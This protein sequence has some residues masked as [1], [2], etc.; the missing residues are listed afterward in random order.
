[1]AYGK[2]QM[3]PQRSKE[4]IKPVPQPLTSKVQQG[5]TGL[6]GAS[7]DAQPDFGG[8]PASGN[9]QPNAGGPSSKGGAAKG[10]KVGSSHAQRGAKVSHA[11]SKKPIHP[12]SSG[13]ASVGSI[14]TMTKLFFHPKGGFGNKAPAGRKSPVGGSGYK[15]SGARGAPQKVGVSR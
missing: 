2:P 13:G 4:G 15:D 1:M 6:E 5:K 8:L 9:F 10:A 11:A 3:R 12:G 14:D 7:D